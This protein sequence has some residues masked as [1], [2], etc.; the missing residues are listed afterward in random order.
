[1]LT[2]LIYL[3]SSSLL[4]QTVLGVNYM[5]HG[6]LLAK[7]IKF[8]PLLSLHGYIVQKGPVCILLVSTVWFETDNNDIYMKKLLSNRCSEKAAAQVRQWLLW[9]FKG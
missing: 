1:M 6:S 7:L 2:R 9:W 3:T 4:F 5:F 8:L